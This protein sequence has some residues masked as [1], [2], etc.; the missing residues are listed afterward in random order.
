MINLNLDLNITI[1]ADPE[2]PELME[3][4]MSNALT[5]IASLIK[6]GQ[7]IGHGMSMSNGCEYNFEVLPQYAHGDYKDAE[8]NTVHIGEDGSIINIT[9]P[10]G[11]VDE[12]AEIV[13]MDGMAW[14]HAHGPL[15]V[16]Q[17]FHGHVSDDDEHGH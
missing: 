13:H 8:G 4:V 2:D 1:P 17:H 14:A 16:I 11:T 5:G 10:D 6:A 3:E 9:R 15:E 7:T 12:S